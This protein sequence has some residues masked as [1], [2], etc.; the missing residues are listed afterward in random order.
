VTVAARTGTAA[1]R[2]GTVSA[3]NLACR[4]AVVSLRAPPGA[5]IGQGQLLRDGFDEPFVRLSADVADCTTP[6][7]PCTG[8]RV[9]AH[10]RRAERGT[11]CHLAGACAQP[12]SHGDERGAVVH[13]RGAGLPP[14]R[15]VPRRATRRP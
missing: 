15:G 4:V 14:C 9:Q 5:G 13:R 1:R 8:R 11:P 7:G 3:V 10:H 2:S 6:P 12:S